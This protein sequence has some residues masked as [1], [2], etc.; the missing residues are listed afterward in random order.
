MDQLLKELA[1]PGSSSG[2]TAAGGSNPFRAFARR[3]Q[4]VITGLVHISVLLLPRQV[5]E[6]GRGAGSAG[7]GSIGGSAAKGGAGGRAVGAGSSRAAAAGDAAEDTAAEL[8]AAGFPADGSNLEEWQR[9]SAACGRRLSQLLGVGR[10][11]CTFRPCHVS[12]DACPLA[13]MLAGPRV[14]LRCVSP[15]AGC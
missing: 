5:E 15:E 1:G 12:S 13:P 10:D 8:A 3:A 7:S 11:V 14:R 4:L 2:G 6:P 9:V